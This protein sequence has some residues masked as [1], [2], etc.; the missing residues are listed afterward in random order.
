MSSPAGKAKAAGKG[1]AKPKSP[2]AKSKPAIVPPLALSASAPANEEPSTIRFADVQGEENHEADPTLATPSSPA[3]SSIR[4]SPRTP[5]SVKSQPTKGALSAAGTRGAL[6]ARGPGPRPTTPRPPKADIGQDEVK[7]EKRQYI[8]RMSQVLQ[9]GKDI[10]EERQRKIQEK[11]E[12]KLDDA[13]ARRLQAIERQKRQLQEEAKRKAEALQRAKE[14]EDERQR[15]FMEKAEGTLEAA[16]Q[17]RLQAI[18]RQRK[19]LHEAAIKKAEALDRAKKIEEER[20][21]ALEARQTRFSDAEARRLSYLEE[22]RRR[23]RE[24]GDTAAA[25]ARARML[26][27]ERLIQ[28]LAA[29]ADKDRDRTRREALIKKVK[30]KVTQLIEEE[31]AVQ[32]RKRKLLQEIM[33]AEGRGKMMVQAP[34]AAAPAIPPIIAAELARQ[35]TQ[36]HEIR[37]SSMMV[38]RASQAMIDQ[39]VVLDL[40][41]YE[42]DVP[43]VLPPQGEEHQPV[44]VTSLLASQL[45]SLVGSV[46]KPMSA[47]PPPRMGPQD[48]WHVRWFYRDEPIE[49]VPIFLDPTL[50]LVPQSRA[51]RRGWSMCCQKKAP[52]K[53]VVD[54]REDGPDRGCV[55]CTPRKPPPFV[56]ES[57]L[58]MN[59]SPGGP[60][61]PTAVPGGLAVPQQQQQQQPRQL[62]VETRRER[63][64]VSS[65]L[66][67]TPRRPVKETTE[68]RPR[69]AWES[70]NYPLAQ[71]VPIIQSD[72]FLIP[73]IMTHR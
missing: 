19:Q 67:C 64:C 59:I 58:V 6:S 33:L 55:S 2:K 45:S 40:D 61:R 60:V 72:P 4:V 5:A 24:L 35:E 36:L 63:G 38:R 41:H 9:R 68:G 22:M 1:K 71:S 28:L 52:P 50:P 3:A 30:K 47:P 21:R 57:R 18:D 13:E 44:E 8:R 66:C 10:E 12:T 65:S 7:E 14:L 62:R 34:G 37:R 29:L 16:E 26:E 70:H 23:M 32:E 48:E 49:G 39:H 31:R 15:R 46:I 20:I 56:P 11:T 43:V 25:L 53:P 42:E 51:F 27:E 69:V 54:A 17:R 73:G